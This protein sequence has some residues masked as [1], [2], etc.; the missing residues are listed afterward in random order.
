MKQVLLLFLM[1]AS[2]TFLLTQCENSGQQHSANEHLH[3]KTDHET[4]IKQFENPNRAKWQKPE[5]VIAALGDLTGKTVADIG[6]GSGYFTFP[7]A[8][9]AAKVIAIDIDQKFLD[10]IEQ[11]IETAEANYVGLIET[12]HASESDP[13]LKLNEAD[14]VL[15]VNTYHHIQ[16][17]VKYFR[18]L[19]KNLQA[20]GQVVIVDYKKKRT[21]MGP[22][23]RLRLSS[24][25]VVNELSEAGYTGIE[26]DDTSLPYQYIIKTN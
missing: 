3:H 2:C 7:L 23:Q 11:R 12:R 26:V 13:Y 10:Y 17:R 8:K 18:S 24:K 4:L 5:V 21:P 1:V 15:I 14:I 19:Q 20:D 25:Q 6:A 22:P 16:D 9:K